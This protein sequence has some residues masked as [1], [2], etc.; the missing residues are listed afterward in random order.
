MASEQR[1]WKKGE[2]VGYVDRPENS[3]PVPQGEPMW[4]VLLTTHTGAYALAGLIAK[5]FRCYGPTIQKRVIKRGRRIEESRDMFPGYVLADLRPGIHDFKRAKSAQG[6]RDFLR[7]E[8]GS[9]SVLKSALVDAMRLRERD[10]FERYRLKYGK[11]GQ[12]AEFEKGQSVTVTDG[13]FASF[14]A[15]VEALDDKGRVQLL[16]DIFGRKTPAWL[17]GDQVEAA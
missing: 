9:P 12:R 2:V 14:F 8:D 13:P 15:K 5:G 7:R 4:H 11:S 6:V 16:I 1:E 10:L 17:D 3:C